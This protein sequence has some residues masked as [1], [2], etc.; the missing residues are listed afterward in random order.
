MTINTLQ[1]IR[2]ACM[3]QLDQSKLLLISPLLRTPDAQVLLGHVRSISL[4]QS[5][6]FHP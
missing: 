4:S 5:L 1:A 2:E 6:G 3:R